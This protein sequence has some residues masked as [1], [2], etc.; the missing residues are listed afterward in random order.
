M[1]MFY[2]SNVSLKKS[3]VDDWSRHGYDETFSE[4][5]YEDAEL[6]FRLAQ[7]Q[8]SQGKEFKILYVPAAVS[9]ARSCVFDCN[10]HSPTSLVRSDSAKIL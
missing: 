6:A 9:N 2:S 1:N 3:I 8:K 4:Y 10:I 5:G 7:S